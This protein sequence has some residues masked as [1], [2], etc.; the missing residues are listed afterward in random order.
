MD[1]KHFFS[2]SWKHLAF[3]IVLVAALYGLRLFR[4]HSTQLTDEM[5]YAY[6][7]KSINATHAYDAKTLCALMDNRY[8][9][10][11]VSITPE[12]RELNQ[13]NREQ[14]CADTEESMQLIRELAAETGIQPEFKYKLGEIV[15]S[16][17][18]KRATVGLRAVM[19]VGDQFTV[20]TVGTETLI[21]RGDRVRSLST[22]TQ[23]TLKTR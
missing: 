22:D 9:G 2:F 19:R 3:G 20:E 18:R 8:Q 6:Y 7:Q 14:A 23:T 4:E 17:D 11:D 16:P 21:R 5:V 15:Y 13:T 12:G 1:L 10:T